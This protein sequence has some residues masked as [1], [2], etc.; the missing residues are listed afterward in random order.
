MI[1][2]TTP[3][4][5]K[6]QPRES[7]SL[8]NE[9]KQ[10][11]LKRGALRVGFSTLKTLEG[12]PPSADITYLLPEAQSAIC[13]ALPLDKEAIRNFLSKKNYKDHVL[14]NIKVN[15]QCDKIAREL[16]L[17]LKE[18]GYK[19]T[20]APP[21]GGVVGTISDDRVNAEEFNKIM[22][23]GKRIT[24][25]GVRDFQYRTELPNWRLTLPPKISQKY[26]AVS[27]GV[28]SYGWSGVVGIKGIGATIILGST[29]TSAKLEP[30]DPLPE[31]ENFC[32]KCK[33]CITAC[34][35]RMMDRD[36]ECKVNLGG[37]EFTHC[38]R[39]DILRC[40]ISCAGF[41]GLDVS[42][43]WSTWSPGRY[44]IPEDHRK[45]INVL[46]KSLLNYKKWPKFNNPDFKVPFRLTCA[47]CQLICFGNRKETAENYRMLVKSG[48]V[49]QNEDGEVI[50]I[51]AEEAH[52][53]FNQFKPEHRKLY[54]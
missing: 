12:G 23:Q 4:I 52:E 7:S 13:F 26:L 30:T 14:D 34:P 10:F 54:H 36:K 3:E 20:V 48:C 21:P 19:A 44:K 11:L 47:N 49:I 32:D 15:T 42:G 9:I 40:A 51:P 45:L 28:A 39:I 22:E 38:D 25:R 27:S 37:V 35:N 2:I 46:G 8:N 1:L 43:K 16:A 53:V 33:L 50:V 29:I 6:D 41:S 24:N 18:K 5:I 31:E 17:W